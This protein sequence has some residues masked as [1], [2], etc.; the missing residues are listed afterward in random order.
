MISIYAYMYN[1]TG[2]TTTSLLTIGVTSNSTTN[3]SS[4]SSNISSIVTGCTVVG[5]SIST[6]TFFPTF[7]FYVPTSAYYY[8]FVGSTVQ[9]TNGNFTVGLRVTSLVRIS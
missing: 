1:A 7:Y 4:G 5:S 2:V 6:Q 3:P 9:N 8:G